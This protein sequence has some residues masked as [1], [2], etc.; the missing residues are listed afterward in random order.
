MVM[1]IRSSTPSLVLAPSTRSPE[2]R[3]AFKTLAKTLGAGDLAGAKQAYGDVVRN[4]PVGATWN[5]QSPF[6]QLGRQL[7][8][9]DVSGAQSSFA[10]M[11]KGQ[12]EQHDRS[13]PVVPP[14]TTPTGSS[15]GGTAG[16]LLNVVA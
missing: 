16:G 14:A 4:A 7:L 2:Q 13:A 12:V 9:G 5:S 3:E 11:I 1:Q 6:A 8:S 15:T 10:E